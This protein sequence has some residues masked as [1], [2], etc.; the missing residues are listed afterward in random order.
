MY[1]TQDKDWKVSK[2][3]IEDLEKFLFWKIPF[4]IEFE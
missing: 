1:V 3:Y 4:L 2:T